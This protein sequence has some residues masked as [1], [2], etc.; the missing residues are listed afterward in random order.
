MGPFGE[1]TASLLLQAKGRC[2]Q[3]QAGTELGALGLEVPP[4]PSV[5]VPDGLCNVPVELLQ[6][7]RWLF[8]L[9]MPDYESFTLTSE[10]ELI[11]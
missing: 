7:F 11:K 9:R 4:A 6:A 10:V 2:P 3:G 5:T 1:E 8:R